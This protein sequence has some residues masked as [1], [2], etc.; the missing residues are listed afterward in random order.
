MT[1]CNSE[2]ASNTPECVILLHGLA[3]KEKSFFKLER[4]LKNK[5]FQVV[6]IGYPSRK[7]TIQEL[8]V[9]VIPTAIKQCSELKAEKIHF[10]THSMGAIL[11]RYYLEHNKVPKLGRVVMLSPPNNGSEVVDKLS[12][13]RLFSWI[14]GP[15]GKQLGTGPGSLPKGYLTEI[16]ISET[17]VI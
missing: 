7:K 2:A 12:D 10:V 6:N 17:I 4:H 8:S 9:D 16:S 1:F 3:R 14:N 5:G 15:A 11:I 13:Y